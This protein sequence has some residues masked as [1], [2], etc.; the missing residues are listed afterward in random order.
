MET[1]NTLTNIRKT[2]QDGKFSPTEA[3]SA[4]AVLSGWYSFYSEQLEDILMRKPSTWLKLRLDNKSDK[5]T[6][7][8]YELTEDGINEI[9]LS[10]RLKRIEKMMSSLK[11]IVDTA[12]TQ[13]SYADK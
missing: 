4:R 12:N 8:A 5:A 11:T 10:M 6:D 9:G 3:V 1:S 13:Y 7:R 2:L